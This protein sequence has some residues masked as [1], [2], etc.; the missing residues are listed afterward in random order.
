MSFGT[1]KLH[2]KIFESIKK[3]IKKLR[4]IKQPWI[5]KGA[6]VIER[7]LVN[8]EKRATESIKCLIK[9]VKYL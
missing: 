6:A 5:N 2:V 1:L 9:V 3:E 8:V 4:G 7:L